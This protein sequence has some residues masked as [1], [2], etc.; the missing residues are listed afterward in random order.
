VVDQQFDLVVIGAGPGGHAAAEAAAHLGARVAIVERGAWGGTCTNIGCIPTKALLVC[1]KQYAHLGKLKRLGVNIGGETTFD[2]KA[3]KRHQESQVRISNLGVQKSLQQVG[4]TL[5]EGDGI[6]KSQSLVEVVGKDGEK[7]SLATKYILIA[8]GS[9]PFV[10]PGIVLSDQ[11]MTSDGILTLNELPQSIAIIGGGVIGVEFATFLAE[12]GVKVT[13]VELL[14]QIVPYEE[15][16]AATFLRQELEKL[17][18]QIHTSTKMEKMVEQEDKVVLTVTSQ[19]GQQEIEVEKAAVCVGRKPVMDKVQLDA[20]GIEYGKA[21]TVDNQQETNIPGIFAIGDVTGGMMLAHRASQQGRALADRLFGKGEICYRE[22]I[23]PSVTYTHPPVA[24]VGLI[25]RE[26]HKQGLTVEVKR[27][28]FGAN[29]LAR[30]E[31]AGQ[32]FVKLLFADGILIGATI[33]G[34][35]ASELIAAL[36]LAIEN[37]ST[38]G[39]MRSWV[40]PHPTLSEVIGDA[41]HG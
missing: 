29:A 12:L 40:L 27:A 38:I 9:E 14:D 18:I 1:S 13:I 36:G 23:I 24:R 39:D 21:I 22:D 19:T 7:Q 33:V 41:L 4:V 30:A 5:V 16:E 20:V 35:E 25:E 3:M 32:G 17:G 15:E 8:W 10:F 37:K 2:Y 26:A 6:V 11:I 31:L 34:E 28:E